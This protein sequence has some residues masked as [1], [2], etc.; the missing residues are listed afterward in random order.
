M[1]LRVSLHRKNKT[2]L[3]EEPGCA[4]LVTNSTFL[5]WPEEFETNI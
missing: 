1:R 4:G 5:G 3:K 2:E